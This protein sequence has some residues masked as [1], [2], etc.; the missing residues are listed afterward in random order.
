MVLRLLF[1][2]LISACA[3]SAD[4]LPAE[5]A[6]ILRTFRAEG[7]KG[8]AFTQAT[9]AS[10]GKSLV[11][12]FDPSKPELVRWNLIQKDGKA[13]TPD[14]LQEYKEKQTRRSGGDTAPDVTKQ[15]DFDSAEKVHEDGERI[16]YRFKLNPGAKDDATAAHLRSTFTFHK[17]TATVEKVELANL[18]PFS[19]MMTVKIKEV[20]TV[21]HY[22]LPSGDTPSLL[23]LITVRVR[24]RAMLV[25]SLDE[26][27]EVRYSNHRYTL[28]RPSP[29]PAPGT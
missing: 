11:E 22:S 15:L 6:S 25:K 27:M 24:G 13:P 17:P 14:E 12:E 9:T 10:G 7:A 3:A 1:A 8:W 16:S 28:K 4:S 21:M 29:T 26:D 18:E 20:R 5:Y 19:P 23:Q 2:L